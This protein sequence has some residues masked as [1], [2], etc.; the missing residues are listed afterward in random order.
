VQVFDWMHAN[1]ISLLYLDSVYYPERGINYIWGGWLAL[2]WGHNTASYSLY[3]GWHQRDRLMIPMLCDQRIL[4]FDSTLSIILCD[5]LVSRRYWS[6]WAIVRR[7]DIT[8]AFYYAIRNSSELSLCLWILP[9]GV[10]KN[11]FNSRNFDI[12]GLIHQLKDTFGENYY[13][14]AL[15]F[16][17]QF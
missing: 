16:V 10:H 17:S 7:I 8:L 12:F 5:N 2:L 15:V 3:M 6:R 14:T 1:F 13:V 11:L 4:K 9:V